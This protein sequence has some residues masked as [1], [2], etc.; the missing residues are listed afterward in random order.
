ML[1]DRTHLIVKFSPISI[2][3]ITPFDKPMCSKEAV[4]C[5]KFFVSHLVKRRLVC[6]RYP[7]LHGRSLDVRHFHGPVLPPAVHARPAVKLEGADGALVDGEL[8]P[9][10]VLLVGVLVE[11]DVS[12]EGA[13][14]QQVPLR[15]EAQVGEAVEG[16]P[17]G[18]V[19][20]A[21]PLL[22]LLRGLL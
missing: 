8:L 2:D 20:R 9:D 15:V 18:D 5:H 12:L 17:Q 22:L 21:V 3:L 1:I 6:L 11:E 14:G 13:P 4:M 16:A 7:M 10:L 19:R